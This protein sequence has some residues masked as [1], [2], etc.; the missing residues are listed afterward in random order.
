MTHVSPKVQSTVPH[1]CCWTP[2]TP[3]LYTLKTYLS[4]KEGEQ[5][6]HTLADTRKVGIRSL[7]FDADEGFFL[8]DVPYQFKGV[9]VHEDAGCFGNAVPAAVWHRRL[10]KL[11]AMAVMPCV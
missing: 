9:C 3:S 10:A 4:Y 8:N 1:P 5:S 11:K 6:V 2:E 7:R